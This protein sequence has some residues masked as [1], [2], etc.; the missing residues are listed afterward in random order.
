V[1]PIQVD[2]ASDSR[3]RFV[4]DDAVVSFGLAVNATF[5]D[6]ARTMGK[7]S[8]RR[9]GNPVAIDVTLA[10]PPGSFVPYS[11]YSPVHDN[12][13]FAATRTNADGRHD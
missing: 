5:E 9:Y 3:L 13:D 11:G 2:H 10:V 1:Q 4:F 7:L 12:S 6:I 8:N